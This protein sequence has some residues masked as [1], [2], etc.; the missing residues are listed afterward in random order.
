MHVLRAADMFPHSYGTTC[1]CSIHVTVYMYTCIY[2]Y[3]CTCPCSCILCELSPAH[4]CCEMVRWRV[5]PPSVG[6][7]LLPSQ[8]QPQ[9]HLQIAPHDV[10]PLHIHVEGKGLEYTCIHV[11]YTVMN[12]HVCVHSLWAGSVVLLYLSVV[13]VWPCLVL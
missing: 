13:L 8:Q 3:T 12:V 2:M 1:T 11:Y 7:A 5:A 9:P 10:C 6:M 4:L